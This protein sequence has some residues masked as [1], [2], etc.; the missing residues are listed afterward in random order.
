MY[1]LTEKNK[2][3]KLFKQGQNVE[4]VRL[5]STVSRST[6]YRWKKQFEIAKKKNY[7]KEKEWSSLMKKRRELEK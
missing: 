1:T 6:L 4:A 3:I 7:S 5:H 2:V